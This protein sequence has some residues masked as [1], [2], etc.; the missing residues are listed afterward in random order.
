[1]SLCGE[2]RRWS[3]PRHRSRSIVD[4][5]RDAPVPLQQNCTGAPSPLEAAR[6]ILPRVR[7]LLAREMSQGAARFSEILRLP[8]SA[9]RRKA[10]AAGQ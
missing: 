6:G 2:G 7:S 1:M 5:S 10:E 8:V 4:K 3:E 9:F